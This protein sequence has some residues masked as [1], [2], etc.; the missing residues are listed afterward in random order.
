[1]ILSHDDQ[2]IIAQCTPSGPGALGLVRISGIHALAIA[3]QMSSL[4]SG[5][6]LNTFPSHTIHYGWI[7]DS[8]GTRI[9]QVLFLLMHSP[10][11]FTGQDTV[12]ITCHN[13]P[14]IIQSI[15]KLALEQ[16]A[17]LATA[18]EFT[19][20]ALLNNKIDMIQAEAINELIHANTQI[21][22]KQ[23]L[24]QVEG[25]FSRWIITL[26][27]QLTTALA[28]SEASV[29]FIDEETMTFGTQIAEIITRSLNTIATLKKTFDQQKQIRDGVK[30]AIIGSVNVG[31]SSFFNALL[32]KNQAIVTNIA[33]T[34]R[35]VLEA[36]LYKN[37]NYWTLIDTAGLRQ[38]D[39]IIEQEGIRRSFEQAQLADII[40]L[41]CD[42]SRPI[43]MQEAPVYS[44]L[45]AQYHHKIIAL[46]SKADLL[47]CQHAILSIDSIPISI[48]D[49]ETIAIVEKQIEQKIEQLFSQIESP[50]LL[51]RRQFNLLLSLEQKLLILQPM[52]ENSIQY[53]LVS[54]HLQDT[55]A[56]LAELTG[57]SVSEAGMDAVFR[58]FC[59]GK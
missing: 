16:G 44:D 35:D 40:I 38:T 17:R 57:K 36:G 47:Q 2:T 48:T 14:F 18:G 49:Q 21:G 39:D 1:V 19:K 58:E 33:G 51:N 13:N 8:H 30:I 52:L 6:K 53:E 25:S 28:F 46:R 32:G 50:F 4:A 7:V 41:M 23:S 42:G 10:Q 45:I 31:K 9:D 22:L 11:T 54:Y 55:I 15:I 24:A 26:E 59:V 37:S 43:S 27:K 3:T 56:H 29:E 34:T 12:E 5:K 20:R